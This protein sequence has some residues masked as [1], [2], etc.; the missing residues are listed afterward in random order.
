MKNELITIAKHDRP[1]SSGIETESLVFVSG[2]G[3]IDPITGNIVGSDIESQ[4]I[5]T[6]ENMRAVL[7]AAD[8]DMNDLVKV[9]VYLTDRKHYNE[10]NE[11]YG[12]YFKAPYPSRTAIYCDLNYDL[13]VEIDGI[14]MKRK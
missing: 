1:F 8:L 12:R 11:I 3:G 9:T 14:A 10:F 4:T 6:L 2:Q 5:Q 13:L 7:H